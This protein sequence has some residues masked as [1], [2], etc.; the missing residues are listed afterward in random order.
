MPEKVRMN[1]FDWHRSIIRVTGDQR[2]SVDLNRAN[3]FPAH[4]T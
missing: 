3:K 4:L 2:F 1:G